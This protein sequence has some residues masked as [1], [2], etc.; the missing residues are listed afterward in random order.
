MLGNRSSVDKRSERKQLRLEKQKAKNSSSNNSPTA[1]MEAAKSAKVGRKRSRNNGKSVAGGSNGGGES[2]HELHILNERERR[3][4]MMNMFS[5]LH[6]LLPQLPPKADKST[7][8]DEAVNYINS[9][10]RT[11]QTLEKQKLERDQNETVAGYEQSIITSSQVQPLESREAFLA[12]HH[13]PS[14][15]H[16]SMATNVPH[17][18]PVPVTPVGFQTWFSPNVVVNTCGNDAQISVCSPKK[19]GL[20]TTILN[21]LENH[22]L[23]VVSAHISSDR[24]R[25][26]YMIHAHA[27]GASNSNQFP[28]AL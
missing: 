15:K 7:I 4:K 23:D 24:Y 10:Q 5:N 2:E 25:S 18:F 22:N 16:M 28:E 21:I 8:V 20:L 27:D 19:P 6:A 12:D 9:L 17:P 26:M 11:L 1:E 14:S 3:K 13:G